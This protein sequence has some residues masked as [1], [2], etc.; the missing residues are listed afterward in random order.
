MRIG[1]R[2]IELL[3]EPAPGDVSAAVEGCLTR[4]GP[5]R[6]RALPRAQIDT[7]L[8][9]AR[10]ERL[11]SLDAG[12]AIADFLERGVA[13][14]WDVVDAVE[15]DNTAEWLPEVSG[16]RWRFIRGTGAGDHAAELERFHHEPERPSSAPVS[17]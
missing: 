11:E 12:G 3:S 9:L 8:R 16:M 10:A 15:P 5:K 1:D 17:P 14:P 2:W 7:A 13:N 4:I 6:L